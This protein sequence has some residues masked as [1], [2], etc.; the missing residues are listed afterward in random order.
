[1]IGSTGSD[2]LSNSSA[3]PDG[4]T[5]PAGLAVGDALSVLAGS[6]LVTRCWSPMVL[7]HDPLHDPMGHASQSINSY[8]HS[9]ALVADAV[10]IGGLYKTKMEGL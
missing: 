10:R 3:D 8:G 7:L 9:A 2:V 5:A 6:V 4:S 1:M